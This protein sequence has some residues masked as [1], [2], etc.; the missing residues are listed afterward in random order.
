VAQIHPAEALR[1]QQA[2]AL[3]V[4][5]READEWD[6]VRVPGSLHLPLSALAARWTELPT[7]AP[8]LFL[9]RSGARSQAAA[10]FLAR[11]GR[12][13]VANV[14]GGILGWQALRLPTISGRDPPARDG[15]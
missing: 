6:D 15:I 7:D 5:V 8:L 3:V 14:M 9:C 13:D 1:Q 10:A 12:S 2:G 11:Q 4:D